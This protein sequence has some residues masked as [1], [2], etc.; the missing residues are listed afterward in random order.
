V[1][2][3]LPPS[4][5]YW[6]RITRDSGGLARYEPLKNEGD[7]GEIGLL[8]IGAN[9]ATRQALV[10]PGVDPDEP[11]THDSA[12]RAA[13]YWHARRRHLADA[14]VSVGFVTNLALAE[15]VENR[16]WVDRLRTGSPLPVERMAQHYV[17]LNGSDK[18]AFAN[19][20]HPQSLNTN[21]AAVLEAIRRTEPQLCVVLE[22]AKV[23]V[24]PYWLANKDMPALFDRLKMKAHDMKLHPAEGMPE[25]PPLEAFGNRRTS[26][27]WSF[28]R[29]RKRVEQA[30]QSVV[31]PDAEH[32]AVFLARHGVVC[33]DVESH[34]FQP[35]RSYPSGDVLTV[36]KAL[37]A[38]NARINSL[39]EIFEDV[40]PDWAKTYP[41]NDTPERAPDDVLTDAEFAY[42]ET[43]AFFGR[44]L[45]SCCAIRSRPT[46]D[47]AAMTELT[48]AM[49]EVQAVADFRR[50]DL[51]L[52]TRLQ[53]TTTILAM[54]EMFGIEANVDLL[55]QL[56]P[57][58]L[59]ASPDQPIDIR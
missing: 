19:F 39:A 47:L 44:L 33:L 17:R 57:L 16:I 6:S 11:D 55:D 21:A 40:I 32:L 13:A 49:R 52:T 42:V 48:S 29:H 35:S 24:G 38:R 26:S 12:E 51:N 5:G 28:P 59:R 54:S 7:P 34:M 46:V 22:S 43:A 23:H 4:H 14:G 45:V 27:V 53:A 30:S 15:H 58:D 31:S 9:N 37:D 2:L 50:T 18:I 8:R 56:N 36:R 3:K 1:K 20:E 41:D 25:T 10:V